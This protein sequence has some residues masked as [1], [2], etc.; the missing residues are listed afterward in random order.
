[1]AR[2]EQKLTCSFFVG[3]K[4]VDK[5]TPEYLEKLSERLGKVM[6]VYYTANLEEYQQLKN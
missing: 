2:K 1:M 5:L 3:G 6:S 4:Q